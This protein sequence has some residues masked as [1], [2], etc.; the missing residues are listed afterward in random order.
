MR[1]FVK[2]E[3]IPLKLQI[4]L[5]RSS[6]GK[7]LSPTCSFVCLLRK[8]RSDWSCSSAHLLHPTSTTFTSA[9]CYSGSWNIRSSYAIYTS[10]SKFLVSFIQP[11]TLSAVFTFQISRSDKYV[12]TIRFVPRTRKIQRLNYAVMHDVSGWNC[13]SLAL[14][15]K[16]GEYLAINK[17]FAKYCDVTKLSRVA[18]NLNNP[19][20]IRR[21]FFHCTA[22]THLPR[23]FSNAPVARTIENSRI[24]AE[25]D[26]IQ[27]FRDAGIEKSIFGIFAFIFR[28][29]ERTRERAE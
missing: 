19:S 9:I 11:Y 1:H 8:L 2:H 21:N 4:I 10:P 15:K 27:L 17:R 16:G 12:L 13:K 5:E 22:A 7:M 25:M 26:S 14:G 24:S 20:T 28:R 23:K 6:F 3:N 29:N 18:R